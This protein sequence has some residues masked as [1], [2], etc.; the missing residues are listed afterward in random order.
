MT[1]RMYQSPPTSEPTLWHATKTETLYYKSQAFMSSVLLRIFV[2]HGE[3][4]HRLSSLFTAWE[5]ADYI[6]VQ[7]QERT[8]YGPIVDLFNSPQENDPDTIIR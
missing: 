6:M 5:H 4:G 2:V 3:T 7:M 8:A 1:A